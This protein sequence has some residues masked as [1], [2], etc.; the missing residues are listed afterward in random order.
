MIFSIFT[1]LDSH[2]SEVAQSC[3]TLC[4]P[5]GCSL[6]GS[7][8]HGIFQAIV[9]EWIAISFSRGSS[10]PRVRTQVS[11]IVDTRF[12]VWAT[13]KVHYYCLI[14]GHFYHLK[15]N[16]RSISSHSPFSPPP[17]P[18][19]HSSNLSMNLYILDILYKWINAAYDLPCIA[20]FTYHD[21]FV[22]NPSY[23]VYQYFPFHDWIISNCIYHILFSHLLIGGHLSCFH[24]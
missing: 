5:M 16:P 10:Q 19:N 8:V 7:S 18:G 4:D 6:P 2:W 22:V 23:S 11:R 9:L 14:P 20:T 24:F 12:T 15:R 3:L 21:V 1:K 13:R 17:S